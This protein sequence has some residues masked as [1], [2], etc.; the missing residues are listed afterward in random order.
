[1][2]TLS[3]IRDAVLIHLSVHWLAYVIPPIG[4]LTEL[5]RA[6]RICSLNHGLAYLLELRVREPRAVNWKLAE[7]ADGKI[8]VS[9]VFSAFLEL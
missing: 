8:A 6:N 9:R 3:M 5:M 4:S 2:L 1:M 7:K